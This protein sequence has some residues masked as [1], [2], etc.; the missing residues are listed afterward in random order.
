M[1]KRVPQVPFRFERLEPRILLSAD[2]VTTGVALLASDLATEDNEA[3]V[4]NPPFAKTFPAVGAQTAANDALTLDE[5]RR[6]W[7]ARGQSN[8]RK[9]VTRTGI[10]VV[11]DDQSHELTIKVPFDPALVGSTNHEKMDRDFQGL[12][13]P[14]KGNAVPG[15]WQSLRRGESVFKVWT[16]LP[17]L[18]EGELP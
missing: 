17:L 2:P 9:S 18:A 1:T 10:K 12:R 7:S 6:F 11:Y 14:Q 16:G 8:D 5:W 15:P 3:N 4:L 13:V